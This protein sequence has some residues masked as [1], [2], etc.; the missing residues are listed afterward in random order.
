M[1]F[2]PDSQGEKLRKIPPWL[3][4]MGGQVTIVK[5]AQRMLY[6][7]VLLLREQNFTKRYSTWG[8]DTSLPVGPSSLS[9][10]TKVRE[11]K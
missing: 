11:D 6:S 1:R 4:R 10:W 5:H 9:A 2:L 7:Q 3:W 8:E